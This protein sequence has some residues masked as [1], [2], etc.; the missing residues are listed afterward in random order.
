[1]SCKKRLLTRVYLQRKGDY[2]YFTYASYST[3]AVRGAIKTEVD[4][5]K[6]TT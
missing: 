2:S 3:S 6:S 4:L 5:Y 1:M